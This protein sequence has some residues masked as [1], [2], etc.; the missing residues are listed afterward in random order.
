M[1]SCNSEPYS[2]MALAISYVFKLVLKPQ[3]WSADHILDQKPLP[4]RWGCCWHSD[5]TICFISTPL[6]QIVSGEVSIE[7]IMPI[8]SS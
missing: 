2:V 4:N 1:N 5:V 8:L 6:K 7:Q 3:T